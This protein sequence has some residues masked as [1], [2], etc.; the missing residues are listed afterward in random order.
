MRQRNRPSLDLESALRHTLVDGVRLRDRQRKRHHDQHRDEPI[1]RI[2]MRV[3]QTTPSAGSRLQARRL[4]YIYTP[5]AIE[6][7]PNLKRAHDLR[8][9]HRKDEG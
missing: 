8:M 6:E 3:A 4:R 2:G 7:Q 5:I 9:R 1:A